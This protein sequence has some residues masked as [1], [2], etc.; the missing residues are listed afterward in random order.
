M[1]CL[2]DGQPLAVALAAWLAFALL[3][4]LLPAVAVL[5]LLRLRVDPAVVIPLGLA[6]CAGASWLSLAS[7]AGGLF[8]ALV[9]ALDATL[10]W[11]PRAGWRL[12]DGP[13]LR[14]ALW[15]SAALLLLF[16]ATQFRFNRCEPDGS[17]ALDPLERVD[18][19]FHVAVTWEVSHGLPPQVPGLAGVPM[20]YHYGPHLV[21]AAALRWAGTHPYDALA[22]FDLALWAVALVLALRSAAWLLGA[23][24]LVVRLAG[25]TPLL[26]DL[27]YLLVPL[28]GISFWSELLL[29]SVQLSLFFANPVIPAVALAVGVLAGLQRA[30]LGQGRGW[31]AVAALL[32]LALPTFKIFLA[33]QLLLGLGLAFLLC[34][35]ER[36]A[37]VL[38]AAPCAVVV[39]VLVLG[40]Q[41]D[42]TGTSL[43]PLGP[44][45]ALLARIGL[46]SPDWGG[47]LAWSGVWLALGLGL[48]AFGLLPAWRALRGPAAGV[49]LAVLALSGWPL[50]LL[51]RII[52]D[53]TFD[54][55]AYFVVHSA[56]FLWV[57]A[58]VGLV[59]RAWESRRPGLVLGL[60][61]AL[62]LPN[63]V[64]LVAARLAT[65]AERVPPEVLEATRALARVSAPGEV[66]L[67]TPFSRWPPPPLVF[68]GRRLA[69]TEYLPYMLQFAPVRFSA[70]RER[71]VRRFFKT[72]DP[73]E[74]RELAA[75]LGARLVCVYGRAP[76]P[77]VRA[78]LR[79]VFERDGVGVYEL[80]GP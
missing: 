50:R 38:V 34:R 32:G 53:G 36:R 61:F 42:S 14:G 69:Y 13:R 80:A 57:F 71:Q 51:L 25:W 43:L 58:L 41:L 4:I 33:A 68:A 26:G 47:Q 76:E 7:G 10:L 11:R 9:L 6:L 28:L 37:L 44:G 64:Q 17:F 31:L 19:A 39:A 21:R 27:G 59:A 29:T 73:R 48:R 12:A 15:P 1:T 63:T 70:E 16:A 5:R 23:P 60:A 46:V 8:P 77:G 79:P 65:P 40:H 75:G 49:A 20:R 66:V 18:T 30:R 2:P 3:A 72:G 35:E 24:R 45:R 22:R 56:V 62:S 55:G 74:A 67:Q 52:P 54:E 78:I